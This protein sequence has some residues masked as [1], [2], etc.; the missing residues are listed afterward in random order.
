MILLVLRDILNFLRFTFRRD[1]KYASL[2]SY[3]QKANKFPLF[4]SLFYPTHQSRVA[5]GGDH[6]PQRTLA[7]LLSLIFVM[8]IIW[9]VAA[10]ELD[11]ENWAV[12]L[13]ANETS[14]LK[15]S[16]FFSFSRRTR[17]SRMANVDRRANSAMDD[18]IARHFH[19]HVNSVCVQWGSVV[20]S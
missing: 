14:C 19:H 11:C 15:F 5:M 1:V 8:I 12:S 4:S 3:G 6:G 7:L 9:L 17:N 2:E 13:C 16:I 10:M 20:K 18:F